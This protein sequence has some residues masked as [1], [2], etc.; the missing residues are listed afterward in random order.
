MEAELQATLP[1]CNLFSIL[2]PRTPP[3]LNNCQ[4]FA[5]PE[6]QAIKG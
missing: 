6:M 5:L 3:L 1:V 4:Q 2:Q